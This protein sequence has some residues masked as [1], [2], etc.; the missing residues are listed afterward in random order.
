MADPNRDRY[1]FSNNF[2]VYHHVDRELLNSALG[3]M[4]VE[5]L[6]AGMS[7]E[8]H[9]PRIPSIV[10]AA[11]NHSNQVETGVIRPVLPRQPQLPIVPLF[12]CPVANC[13]A[14]FDTKPRL[15][16]HKD[17]HTTIPNECPLCPTGGR[18]WYR[19]DKLQMHLTTAH[20][21]FNPEEVVQ[22]INKMYKTPAAGRGWIDRVRLRL[23]E[24]AIKKQNSEYHT[25]INQN[26]EVEDTE[27]KDQSGTE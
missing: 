6:L 7:G 16:R 22:T 23:A 21:P 3:H 26:D 19:V 15:R 10:W 4:V 1:Q 12:P 18:L 9:P 27:F 25:T 2:N 8:Q 20:W 13:H 14:V 11:V 17:L 5:N 24:E